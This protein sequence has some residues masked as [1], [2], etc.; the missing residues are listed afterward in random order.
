M[1]AEKAKEWAKRLRSGNY[2]QG[3]GLLQ[4]QQG[5]EMKYCCLGVACQM[6]VEAGVIEAPEGIPSFESG[7][8]VFGYTDSAACDK[9]TSPYTAILPPQVR[10]Y[11]GI[12]SATGEYKTPQGAFV[13]DLTLDNDGGG[14][15]GAAKSFAEIADIIEAH[16]KEL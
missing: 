4:Y 11:M 3:N 9:Y 6:A 5:T 8:I 7:N 16:V 2:Q 12:K 10:D 14:N 1:D 13:N 15:V